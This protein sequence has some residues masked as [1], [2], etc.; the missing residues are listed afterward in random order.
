ME[1]K[2]N[3]EQKLV[4]LTFCGRSVLVSPEDAKE[5]RDP[6]VRAEYFN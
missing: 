4:L 6:E 2:T 3:L 5:F 1:E